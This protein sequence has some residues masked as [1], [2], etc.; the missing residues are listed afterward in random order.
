MINIS[1]SNKSYRYLFIF[2]VLCYL[3]NVHTYT[4][5]YIH[6]YICMY[7]NIFLKIFSSYHINADNAICFLFIMNLLHKRH[8]YALHFTTIHP[9]VRYSSIIIIIYNLSLFSRSLHI[10]WSA[11]NSITW[12]SPYNGWISEER[13]P[14][15]WETQIPESSLLP[16]YDVLIFDHR[17]HHSMAW[18]SSSMFFFIIIYTPFTTSFSVELRCVYYPNLMELLHRVAVSQTS[19]DILLDKLQHEPGDD[20]G[21]DDIEVKLVRLLPHFTSNKTR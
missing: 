3:S 9:F 12:Y 11:V 1:L 19:L 17:F 5:I 15:H 6:T 4:Y 16:R 2:L 13:S 8:N 7:I 14:K 18:F 10:S 21:D 20:N